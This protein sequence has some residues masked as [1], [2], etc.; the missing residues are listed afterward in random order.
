MADVGDLSETSLGSPRF[1]PRFIAVCYHEA[2]MQR[3]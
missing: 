2:L 1:L 3:R